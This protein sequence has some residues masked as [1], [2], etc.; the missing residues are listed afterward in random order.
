M[1]RPP[2]PLTS[3]APLADAAAAP[4]TASPAASSAPG[5]DACAQAGWFQAEARRQT[6]VVVGAARTNGQARLAVLS[7]SATAGGTESVHWTDPCRRLLLLT[8]A[9]QLATQGLLSPPDRPATLDV[10]GAPPGG[11]A[12]SSDAVLLRAGFGHADVWDPSALP[13]ILLL[14]DKAAAVDGLVVGSYRSEPGQS[15]ELHTALLDR[16]GTILAIADQAAPQAPAASPVSALVM[17]VDCSSSMGRTD[18]RAAR[19]LGAYRI[20]RTV[21][22]TRDPTVL[23]GF[24]GFDDKLRQ[25]LPPAP[26][27]MPGLNEPDDPGDGPHRQARTNAQQVLGAIAQIDNG[28]FTN[29]VLALEWARDR[30]LALSASEGRPVARKDILLFT[31]GEH[32]T[33]ARKPSS[34]G[35]SLV[36]AGIRVWSVGLGPAADDPELAKLAA[37]TGGRYYHVHNGYDMEAFFRTFL[38][39]FSGHWTIAA[40]KG[41]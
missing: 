26:L 5:P 16:R 33:D 38:A 7:F 18:P 20:A 1:A 21:A 2:A 3:Q 11:T 40:D 39:T 22:L 35:P 9:E 19:M 6:S 25:A 17:A 23:L 8:T 14:R 12:T 36:A 32:N 30:L 37:D 41:R 10:A 24:V 13:S 15:P 27:W 34:L 29:I 4:A 31:D 28:R